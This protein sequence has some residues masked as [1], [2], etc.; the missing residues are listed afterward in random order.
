LVTPELTPCA[1]PK[2]AFYLFSRQCPCLTPQFSLSPFCF[3]S[4]F[5]SLLVYSTWAQVSLGHCNL[6]DGAGT[7][8]VVVVPSLMTMPALRRQ[9]HAAVPSSPYLW[10]SS[11]VSFPPH[12]YFYQLFS[13]SS[14]CHP[15]V[16]SVCIH[17]CIFPILSRAVVLLYMGLMPAT[18]CQCQSSF[19]R[20]CYVMIR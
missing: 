17:P 10:F 13:V 19:I 20:F 4:F 1:Q 9:R 7:I 5:P 8:F 6:H 18:F 12:M 3:L 16:L 15:I 2:L 11:A 14:T